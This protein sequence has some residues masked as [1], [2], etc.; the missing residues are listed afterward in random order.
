MK[1]NKICLRC[2]ASMRE[3]WIKLHLEQGLPITEAAKLAGCHQDTLYIWKAN[4]LKYGIEGLIDKSRAP[5]SHPNE[6][7]D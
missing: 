4:F 7:T 6:Y 2:K 5:L 3:K 1:N